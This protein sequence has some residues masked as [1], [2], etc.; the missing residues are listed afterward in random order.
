[1]NIKKLTHESLDTVATFIARMQQDF[2]HHIPY[3]GSTADDIAASIQE[4]ADWQNRIL[5]AYDSGQLMGFIGADSSDETQ[6]AWIHGPFIDHV[7]WHP[8][9]DALYLA[10]IDQIIPSGLKSFEVFGDAR[11]HNLQAFAQRHHFDTIVSATSLGLKRDQINALP[12]LPPASPL[13]PHQHAA[14]ADLHNTIFP[15]TY[16]TG[17]ELIQQLDEHHQAFVIAT[18]DQLQGY[19]FAKL[20]N[21]GEGYIDFLG[22]TEAARGQGFGT[23]LIATASQWLMAFPQAQEVAL[24]VQAENTGAIHLYTRIGFEHIRTMQAYR[25]F[26]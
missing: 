17:Q 8:R 13:A 26:F 10:A 22:V 14:F 3:F 25:K 16:Y 7:D 21:G 2:T 1:M 18:D 6:R 19:I 11:H 4:W 23:R 12:Q 20:D 9:A 24:T 15:T 5:L